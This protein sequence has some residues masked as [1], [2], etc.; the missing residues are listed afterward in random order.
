MFRCTEN[1]IVDN[2]TTVTIR[3]SFPLPSYRSNKQ[4]LLLN[5]PKVAHIETDS[6]YH[7][8]VSIEYATGNFL[9]HSWE[10]LRD[11]I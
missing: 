3:V 11:F 2:I 1:L 9:H 5:N 8:L 7:D 4:M 6:L 10:L